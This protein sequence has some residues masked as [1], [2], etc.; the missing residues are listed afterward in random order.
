ML[1][2]IVSALSL[3]L[4]V[5]ALD[6]TNGPGQPLTFNRDGTFQ[7]SI[8]EDLHYGEGKLRSG[9]TIA[10]GYEIISIPID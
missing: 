3:A 2:T 9:F 7:I 5:S 10:L 4:V 8:I 1:S 6:R